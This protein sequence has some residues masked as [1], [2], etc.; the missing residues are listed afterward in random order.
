MCPILYMRR[1]LTRGGQRQDLAWSM[2]R[3]GRR[4]I[5]MPFTKSKCGYNYHMAA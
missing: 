5:D 1:L 2:M 3:H 4:A